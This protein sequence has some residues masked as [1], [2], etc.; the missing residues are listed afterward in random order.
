MTSIE[1]KRLDELKPRC[2]EI[3]D[4]YGISLE[5]LN[6]DQWVE[7]QFERA[8]VDA[9]ISEQELATGWITAYTESLAQQRR[10]IASIDEPCYQWLL[11]LNKIFTQELPV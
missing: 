3:E 7:R 5:I 8:L 1:T 4:I 9:S 10:N 2:Q 11:T 6:F